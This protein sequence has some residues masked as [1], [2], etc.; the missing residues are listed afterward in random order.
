MLCQYRLF[1]VLFF[2]G[3]VFNY[4]YIVLGCFFT[5]HQEANLSFGGPL[6][7]D[8]FSKLARRLLSGDLSCLRR[9]PTFFSDFLVCVSH[10]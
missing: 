3:T 9:P 8:T 2:G 10:R 7:G 5:G 1:D 4:I 6:F